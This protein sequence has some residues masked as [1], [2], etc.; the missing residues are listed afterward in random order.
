MTATPIPAFIGQSSV[1]VLL[2]PSSE[3]SWI[4]P[5]LVQKLDL[6]CS[7][8]ISGVQVATADVHVPTDGGGYH[9][10]LPLS[11][12]YHL[13]ADIVLGNNWLGHCK[14]IL[15]GDRRR[16]LKPLLTTVTDLLPPHSWCS[17]NRLSF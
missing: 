1:T 9:S 7:F 11:V 5:V 6:P 17:T 13:T 2:D 14:R 10:H 4:S 15:S 8:G 12:S 3:T 16:I